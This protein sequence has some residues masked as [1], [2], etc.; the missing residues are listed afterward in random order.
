MRNLRDEHFIA[1]NGK[2][3][4]LTFAFLTNSQQNAYRW[5]ASTIP[6]SGMC[7]EL[8]ESENEQ[9]YSRDKFLHAF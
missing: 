6:M 9:R 1:A 4:I 3:K 5:V 7:S 2:K 8:M